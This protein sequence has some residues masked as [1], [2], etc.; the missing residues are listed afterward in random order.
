MNYR[1]IILS[2]F[3]VFIIKAYS[4]D[5]SSLKSSTLN[6]KT[7]FLQ[8]K[9]QANYGLVF[10]GPHL[11]FDYE[12][13]RQSEKSTIKLESGLGF[14]AA[15]GRGIASIN[16]SLKPIHLSYFWPIKLGTDNILWFGA[17]GSFNYRF[18]LYPEL[19]SGHSYWFSLFDFGPTLLY[20]AEIINKK[21]KFEIASSSFG[22]IS[23]PVFEPEPYFYDLQFTDVVN[24]LNSN[25]SFGSTNKF[26]H[27]KFEISLLNPGKRL[28]S[29]SYIFEMNSYYDAPK[30]TYLTQTVSFN[31]KLGK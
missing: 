23:R 5:A 4:Q 18:H 14:G 19:H 7:Q 9:D 1:L 27:T 30:V 25:L 22:F 8:I 2:L 20:E 26:S 24:K 10:N 31:L 29:M 15:F 6:I 16:F 12:F 17:Y 28:L 11:L 21:F 13:L 3:S